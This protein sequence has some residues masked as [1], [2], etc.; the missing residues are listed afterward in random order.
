MNIEN[1]DKLIAHM[2]TLE[3]VPIPADFLF[4]SPF[5]QDGFNMLFYENECGTPMCIAGHACKLSDPL[6]VIGPAHAAEWLE[7]DY[8]WALDNLFSP[9]TTRL[10]Y[11]EI[12][13]EQAIAALERVRAAGWD[14][15]LMGT[16]E[17]WGLE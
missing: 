1:L 3:F 17:V 9:Y 13:L 11:N 6:R 15:Q 10:L 12:T 8:S 2:R 14:Y 16:R 4:G 5:P 7:L